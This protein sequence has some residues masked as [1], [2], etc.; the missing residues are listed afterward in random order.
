MPSKCRIRA[1]VLIGLAWTIGGCANHT[2][3]PITHKAGVH[4]EPVTVHRAGDHRTAADSARRPA[5]YV[6]QR[7]DTLYSIAWRF[8][9]DFRSLSRWNRIADPNVIYTGQRL[10]LVAAAEK[11]NNAAVAAKPKKPVASGKTRRRKTGPKHKSSPKKLTWSWPASGRVRPASSALGTK[12]IEIWGTRGRPVKAAA[13]G[14]VV[15]SGSGLRG[16]GQLIIVKHSEEFLSAYAHNDRLLVAEGAT[17][18]PG[19]PIAEMGDSDAKRVMLHFEIRRDGK[20][21][22]PIDYLPRR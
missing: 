21:V 18:K 3:A 19:Q 12:G 10:R 2:R 11:D 22:E 6:V 20:A 17:V 7:G 4:R 8:G 15:Y 1:I 5:S 9:V 16:Y 14:T 13:G